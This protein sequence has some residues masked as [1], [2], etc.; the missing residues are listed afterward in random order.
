MTKFIHL[1]TFSV[2]VFLCFLFVGAMRTSFG[3]F[4][5]GIQVSQPN[6]SGDLGQIQ[7]SDLNCGCNSPAGPWVFRIGTSPNFSNAASIVTSP[8]TAIHGLEKAENLL[9]QR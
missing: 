2:K 6:C 9:L 3:Q 1:N 7:Y 4:C 8:P 5:Y